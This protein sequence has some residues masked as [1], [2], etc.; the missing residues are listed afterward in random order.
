MNEDS[1]AY[2]FWLIVD[3]S[4]NEE[5]CGGEFIREYN[6]PQTIFDNQEVAEK[7]L[8]E[9]KKE[10]PESLIYLLEA[11]HHAKTI[12]KGVYALRETFDFFGNHK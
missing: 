2:K 4:D 3:M 8:L 12:G 11:T 9:I 5:I 7:R 1:I 10:N 6:R